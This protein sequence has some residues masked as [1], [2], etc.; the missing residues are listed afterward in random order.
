MLSR[1]DGS[2]APRPAVARPSLPFMRCRRLTD[3]VVVSAVLTAGLL[4]VSC[5]GKDSTGSTA[6]VTSRSA[7]GALASLLASPSAGGWR[8]AADDPFEVWVCHIPADTT[9][10]IY[11]GL[12][13]RLPLTPAGVTQAVN[14]RVSF[15]F[16]ELSHGQYRPVFSVG[17]E[18]TI[19]ADDEPQACVDSAIA[20]AGAGA[21]A[22]LVVADAEHVP[23]QPGGFGSGGDPCP[24]ETGCPVA[25]SRRAAYV[26]ASDFGP[27]WADAPPMD[28]VEHEIGHTLGWVHSAV[29][30]AG[31][32]LSGLDV[33]SNSAAPREVDPARRD[34]PATLAVNLLL[35][36]WLPADDV[37]EVASGT[38]DT[39]LAASAGA[40][41]TRMI[42]LDRAGGP[43]YTIELLTA[44][45]LDDH[46]PV[47]GVAVHEVDLVE[48]S[49]ARIVPMIGE[50]PYTELLQPGGVFRVA[51][52]ELTVDADWTVHVVDRT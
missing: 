12:P 16:D 29:D 18:V 25:V 41:G 11:G 34:A 50:P 51:G 40:S 1:G 15:Y 48:G 39:T 8:T 14:V 46:L 36:G 52:W 22:V 32:Y 2:L 21:E 24:T 17:G 10:A 6:Q 47:G 20:S 49:I 42:V 35:A 33:M 5:A 23:D 3:A 7:T 38:V 19:G 45:G 28:L 30:D 26:G 4:L 43:M 44:D 31:R 37:V 9:A 27:E 13:L